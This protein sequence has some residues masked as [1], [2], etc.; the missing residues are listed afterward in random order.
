MEGQSS[1]YH[2][3]A[4]E[5]ASEA[6]TRNLT[7]GQLNELKQTLASKEDLSALETRINE[8]LVPFYEL[9]G[10]FKWVKRL[11]IAIF[12]ILLKIAFVPNLWTQ[13]GSSG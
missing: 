6:E 10:E 8:K 11:L 9:R 2:R 12:V 13:A 7:I 4:I 5:R 1:E 3:R